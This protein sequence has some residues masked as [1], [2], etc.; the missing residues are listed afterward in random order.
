MWIIRSKK[1]SEMEKYS[2][3]K[4]DENPKKTLENFIKERFKSILELLNNVDIGIMNFF[5]SN[6][7]CR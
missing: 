3:V 2:K 4:I 5:T 6:T 1:K 7:N